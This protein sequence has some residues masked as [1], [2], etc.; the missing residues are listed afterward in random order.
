MP[1]KN[2]NKTAL[3]V[4]RNVLNEIKK[5]NMT[6]QE[7]RFFSIYLA[8][9]DQRDISTRAVR[10]PLVD[11]QKIMD[12]GRLNIEQLKKTT[13]S[14]LQKV[15]NV[16]KENGGYKGFQLFK[17]CD[18]DQDEETKEWY[19]EIDAHDKALPLM[20]EFKDKYF[21]YEL[22][23]VLGLTSKNQFRMYEILKQYESM[24]EREIS[25]EQL[26]DWLGIEPDEYSG[27]NGFSHFRIYV[28]E[29]CQKALKEKTDICYEFKKGKG[30]RGGKW[31]TIIFTIHKNKDYKSPVN[32]EAFT[33]IC[34]ELKENLAKKETY[35]Y[36]KNKKKKGLPSFEY[37]R[38]N[39]QDIDKLVKNHGYD[40]LDYD[41][42]SNSKNLYDIDIDKLSDDE[43]KKI[44]FDTWPAAALSKLT[45]S[46][47]DRIRNRW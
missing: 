28:L 8:K 40:E 7:L 13:N 2:I 18:V 47:L 43:L 14:L 16:P 26:K 45:W 41:N 15:V 35:G 46:D 31:L 21:K 19:V 34:P 24:G 10:F 36:T 9:I 23:N 29:A 4:K 30:G 32:L 27:A 39:P 44:D 3:V 12:L 6:F 11:F 37:K 20:F 33:K 5:N 25:I 38:W 22:W 1:K 42:D 17:E